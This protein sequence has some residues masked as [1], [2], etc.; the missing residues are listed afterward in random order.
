MR[1]VLKLTYVCCSISWLFWLKFLS[2]AVHQLS[3]M[4]SSVWGTLTC[5]SL[6]GYEAIFSETNRFPV[7]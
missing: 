2:S 4:L 5:Y 3:K 1:D 6:T 7:S